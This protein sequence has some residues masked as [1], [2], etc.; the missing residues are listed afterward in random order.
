MLRYIIFSIFL[1]TP[2]QGFSATAVFAGGCF[3]CMESDFQ[4]VPGV[5][6]V[7][8]GF[9][10]GT[11]PNPT[12]RGP[13]DGHYEAVQISYDPAIIS[14]EQL[15]T[16]FWV[17]VDPFDAG[18]QFC[19]RGESYR[20]ALF[21]QGPEERELAEASKADVQ[22]LFPGR[23]VVTPVLERATFF[24][25]EAY[26]QDYYKK[27]PLRYRYYRYSCGRDQRLEEVWKGTELLERAETLA[28]AH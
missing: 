2:L 6:D 26:H 19:D 7:I 14:F 11:H 12:Y 18:G 22:K 1:M 8:S 23:E 21:V 13:H 20:T 9:T 25:V 28:P 16:L 3:W 5:T 27:N 4:D 10:G 15:L 24:P 17:S